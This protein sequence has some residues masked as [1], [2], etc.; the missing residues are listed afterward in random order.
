MVQSPPSLD[1]TVAFKTL[2][3]PAVWGS[4]VLLMLTTVFL[5][6]ELFKCVFSVFL[7]E[8]L[9]PQMLDAAAH[10]LNP[11]YPHSCFISPQSCEE[12]LEKVLCSQSQAPSKDPGSEVVKDPVSMTPLVRRHSQDRLQ[13]HPALRTLHQGSMRDFASLVQNHFLVQGLV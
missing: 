2:T 3:K 10:W 9:T 7:V 12:V 13:E 6:Q 5:Y 8:V 1:V 11:E 4:E